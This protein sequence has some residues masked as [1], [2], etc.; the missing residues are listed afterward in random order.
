MASVLDLY[1]YEILSRDSTGKEPRPVAEHGMGVVYKAYDLL[2]DEIVALKIVR[3]EVLRKQRD[4]A[5]R[6]F[7]AEAIAGAR[8]GKDCTN[9]VRVF[10][11]GQMDDILYMGQ[12]WVPGGN[13]APLCGNV[14][15]FKARTVCL[16]IGN[17]VR[18]AHKNGIVHSDIAPT[19]ILYDNRR[20]IYKLSD[21][22]LLKLVSKTSL[23]ISG[24]SA[25]LTGGRLDYMPREHF[26]DPHQ[27]GF[28]TDVYALAV[29]FYVLLTGE[30][31]PKQDGRYSVPGIIE[32]K[33][34][35]NRKAPF[36]V[37]QLLD[38]F[39]VRR[40]DTHNIEEFL[41]ELSAVPV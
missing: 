26:D 27:I 36:R 20:D 21:F 24:S 39:I 18:A 2:L 9:I 41:Q 32:I 23:S 1:R 3:D 5:R 22:G 38:K 30:L 40:K 37:N 17:A 19:N 14:T 35:K 10:D 34:D 25:F 7:L 11:I 16:Q 4:K 12:E 33:G 29:T 13:I 6:S 31:P 28:S 15:L 8:L